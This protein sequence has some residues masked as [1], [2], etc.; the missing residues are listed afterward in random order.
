MENNIQRMEE[1][2]ERMSRL[3]EKIGKLEMEKRF[4]VEVI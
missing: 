4:A 1:M 2:E 3:Q